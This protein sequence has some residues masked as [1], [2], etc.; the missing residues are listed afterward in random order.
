MK[1]SDTSEYGKTAQPLLPRKHE[2]TSPGEYDMFPAYSLREGKIEQGF[3]LL[4]SHL[5]GH[6]Q[7][8]IDGYIGVLWDHFQAQMDQALRSHGVHAEWISVASALR[9]AQEIDTLLEPF[10][11]GDDPIFGKRFTGTVTDFF[12]PSSLASTTDHRNS[13]MT[14]Y[15]GIGAALMAEDAYL[16]LYPEYSRSHPA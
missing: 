3:F 11:G 15:Y 10:L 2:P 14:I 12:D 1:L 4:A 6:S 8:V 7:V 5:L 16:V 13:A 9:P